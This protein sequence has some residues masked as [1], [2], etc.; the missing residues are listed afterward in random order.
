MN[1]RHILLT[2]PPGIGKTTIVQ[3]V[4]DL[5][6]ERTVKLRGFL[7]EE[8]RSGGGR[9]GFD[10]VSTCGKRGELARISD[11][12]SGGFKVGRYTPS[13]VLIL[14]EIGK[15]E[16]F[17]KPFLAQTKAAFSKGDV[18][19]LATIPLAANIPLVKELKARKDCL[20]I[21]VTQE[22]RNDLPNKILQLL[23]QA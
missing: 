18:Q 16:S 19:I 7:S 21:E 23:T 10:I 8:V 15:M 13:T 1:T 11:S 5:L 4:C 20:V 12:A 14:D 22:N 3:K 2:G 6:K 9:I 17:S